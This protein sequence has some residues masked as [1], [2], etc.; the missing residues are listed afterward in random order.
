MTQNKKLISIILI[1]FIIIFIFYYFLFLKNKGGAPP[2]PIYKT[3]L[4]ATILQDTKLSYPTTTTQFNFK[5]MELK[6]LPPSFRFLIFPDIQNIIVQ[7]FNYN[8]NKSGF[9]IF[10]ELNS[11][12]LYETGKNIREYLARQK[13]LKL[14]DAKR[15][16]EYSLL[17]FVGEEFDLR[18]ILKKLK[19]LNE[20]ISM[21][22]YIFN[23]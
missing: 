17:E 23:K 22:C 21:E 3:N 4:R 20:K 15:N 5:N 10:G 14:L 7:K 16:E 18:V 11:K 13:S 1:F 2:Q 12:E 8:Q 19:N 9:L 6:D